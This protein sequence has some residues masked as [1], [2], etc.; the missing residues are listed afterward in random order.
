MSIAP[1]TNNVNVYQ[2]VQNINVAA[3]GNVTVNAV[4]QNL[5]AQ[6]QQ[7][8]DAKQAVANYLMQ[9]G[10]AAVD[11]SQLEA[12]LIAFA[13]FMLMKAENGGNNTSNAKD[14]TGLNGVNGVVTA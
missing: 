6:I 1:I 9:A 13:V 3:G 8:G 10:T 11:P 12:L 5:T 4:Q 2:Q 7:S 14:N